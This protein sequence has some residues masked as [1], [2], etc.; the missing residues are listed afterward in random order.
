MA[1]CEQKDFPSPW[2]DE[3]NKTTFP[4]LS[5]FLASNAI[6]E[7]KVRVASAITER[8]TAELSSFFSFPF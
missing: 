8:D 3:L 6:L 1:L 5:S 4:L 2:T 7:H